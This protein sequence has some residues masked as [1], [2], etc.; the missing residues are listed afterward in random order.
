[1][2]YEYSSEMHVRFYNVRKA[3]RLTQKEIG[4]ALGITSG[5]YSKLE[6]VEKPI[7]ENCYNTLQCV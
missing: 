3:L 5:Y 6:S 4:K 7:K 2:D 1:M